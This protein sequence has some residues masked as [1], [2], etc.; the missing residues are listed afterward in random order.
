MK[1]GYA[2]GGV[3]TAL[4]LAN[5]GAHAQNVQDFKPQLAKKDNGPSKLIGPSDEE[6]SSDTTPL[7]RSLK[8]IVIVGKPGQVHRRG[9]RADGVVVKDSALIV[10]GGVIAAAEEHLGE[11]LSLK[12][13]GDMTREIVLAYRDADLP[14]VNVVAPEQDVTNGVLQLIVVLGH[15]GETRVEGASYF[16]VSTYHSYFTGLTREVIN[17]GRVLDDLRYMNRNP[18]R[19]VDAIYSPGKAFGETDITL[20]THELR[21]LTFYAGINNEG[22]GVIGDYRLFAGVMASDFMGLDE[23]LG[24]QYTTTPEFE[25]I[26]AHVWTAQFPMPNHSELQFV[27]AYVTSHSSPD[28]N[29]DTNGESG[30]LA[31]YYMTQL[32]R[33]AGIAQ[34]VKAGIEFKSSNNDLEFG[35]T[36]VSDTTTEIYQ[37]VFGYSAEKW[38]SL[39]RTR[40]DATAYYAPGGI[41]SH[42]DKAVFEKVRAGAEANYGYLT[43][44]LDHRADF[45]GDWRLLT[46]I[47]GQLSSTNLL[48]SEKMILGGVG[49]VRGFEPNIGSADQGILANVTLYS[50]GISIL[51]TVAYPDLLAPVYNGDGEMVYESSRDQLRLFGFFDYGQGSQKFAADGEQNIKMASLGLG[52]TYE[53]GRFWSAELAYG[54]QLLDEGITDTDDGRV[55]FRVTMRK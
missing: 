15:L 9:R 14:I 25:D 41:S 23:V 38:S 21:P 22:S 33:F 44:G 31:A 24:Y 55:H 26:H 28:A 51:G 17:G 49:S 19:R 43:L 32:P 39:G 47:H 16:P 8:G 40:F 2:V 48:S 36:T 18:F 50:P 29:I 27:G 11:A 10:P 6:A 4:L 52:L 42:N 20:K 12:S 53:I 13:L 54:W 34:D 46:S 37:A 3:L 35:G 7:V 1:L 30:Q 45:A 5:S